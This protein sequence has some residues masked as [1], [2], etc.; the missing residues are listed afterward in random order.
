MVGARGPVTDPVAK[1]V[2]DDFGA[3]GFLC[4]PPPMIDAA[5]AVVE[6]AGVARSDMYADRF[7]PAKS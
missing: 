1:A 3:E 7:S 5:M 2:H 4:G 6:T